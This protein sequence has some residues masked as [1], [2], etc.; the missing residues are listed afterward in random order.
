MAS[1]APNSV[2]KNEVSSYESV[3]SDGIEEHDPIEDAE[4]TVASDRSEN[5]YK[6]MQQQKAKI[7]LMK[8]VRYFLIW[9]T[10]S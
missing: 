5:N 10:K 9:N 3:V 8:N 2:D 6:R 4:R 7:L 1:D